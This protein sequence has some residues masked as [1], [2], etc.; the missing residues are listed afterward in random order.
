ML[1][2]H[3]WINTSEIDFRYLSENPNAIDLLKQNEN[4]ISSYGLCNNINPRIIKYYAK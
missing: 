4:K 2:L 3:D 1:K